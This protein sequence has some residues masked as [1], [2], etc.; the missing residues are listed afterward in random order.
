G[1]PAEGG[2][3]G[4]AAAP[5]DRTAAVSVS[6]PPGPRLVCPVESR[7]Q[8]WTTASPRRR[9]RH[10]R[11]SGRH[12]ART[13][14][15][16]RVRG[17]PLMALAFALNC[18]E[19]GDPP[20]G[21]ATATTRGGMSHDEV[22]HARDRRERVPGRDGDG[23]DAGDPARSSPL[24]EA[25]GTAPDAAVLRGEREGARGIHREGARGA[26]HVE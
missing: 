14:A 2:P 20:P 11:E 7:W 6:C 5:L 21:T 1:H 24:H 17:F 3:P 9:N 8:T 12:R 4:P 18:E 19:D 15:A 23:S 10:E 16:D 26:R 25:A 13:S 22:A